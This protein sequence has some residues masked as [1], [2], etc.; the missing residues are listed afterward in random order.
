[1]SLI[2]PLELRRSY[3]HCRRCGQGHL[4]WERTLGLGA[5]QL[6]P[7]ASEVVSMLGV[8]SSFAEVS[9]RTLKKACGLRLSESTVERTTEGAGERLRQ[10]LEQRVKFGEPKP[11]DW[12]RDA[13]G[14]SCAY[15]SLDATGVRQQGEQGAAAEGRMAYVAMIYNPRGAD[16]TLERRTASAPHQVRYL[17]GFYELDA[18]GIELR[19]HPHD[20]FE[21]G[22]WH[23]WQHECFHAERVQPFKQVFRELYVVTKQEKK[24]GAVSHRYDGQQVQPKQALALFGSR[25]WNTRDGI[26]K[27]FHDAG[28]TANVHF[29]SG[30]TTPLEVEGWT[31][32]GVSFTPRNEWKP[33]QLKS[34]PSRLFSEVMRD[35]DLVVSVAH[36]GGVDPEASAS[37]VEMRAGLLRETCSLLKLK[38][39]RLKP[40]HAVKLRRADFYETGD[41]YCLRFHEKGGKVREIPVRHD[42]QRWIQE[43]LKASAEQANN[44]QP[45]APMFCTTVR[46]TKRLTTRPM[47]ADDMGRMLKRRLHDAGL[48]LRLSPHSLRV[49][50]LTDLLSQGLSL[51]DV[52]NLAGHADPR[53]TRLYDRRQRQVTRNIVERISV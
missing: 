18:L 7:A 11:W 19:G 50:T 10:L 33:V 20:L 24:G 31:L 49:A 17:A 42:L 1:V 28:L 8:Q 3:Y 5:T 36:A 15:V 2:G 41:Q 46:R 9:E 6:T 40:T 32:A 14:R 4:P 38:N 25:G 48:S 29:Q 26:F 27:V 44:A 13:Q 12:E 45:L 52:Q 16:R 51:D 34:V 53:T 21:G 23:A 39:V 37:T 47:T 43:Y 35:L 30:V 22:H